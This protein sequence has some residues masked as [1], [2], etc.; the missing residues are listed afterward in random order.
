MNTNQS[1]N[2]KRSREPLGQNP[3][4][5]LR[6]L[7]RTIPGR[8]LLKPL[9]CP[10][11]SRL[12]GFFLDSPLSSFMIDPFLK[13]H[14][15]IRMSDFEKKRY[16]SYNDF[17]T[18]KIKAS[19]RPVDP[20]PKGLISPCD[21]HLSVYPIDAS[22]VFSIKD[23]CYRVSDLLGNDPCSLRFDGGY[24]LIFRLAV[25][26]YHR[27]CYPDSGTF[28]ASGSIPGEYHTVQPI[29]LEHTNI[30]KR[31][32]REYTI[33]HTDHFG[34]LAQVEVGALLVG[35]IVNH[36]AKGSFQKGSEK[37]YFEFG[38]STIVL[39]VQKDQVIIDE[40]LL[41]NTRRGKET[42][43]RFGERIGTACKL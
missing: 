18:R 25:T 9:V 26:D 21:S 13:K 32:T 22:S 35:R 8:L 15:S 37:G 39:L 33:L 14:P 36:P 24:C 40:E 29:A 5:S 27:Y 41:E 30:Y 20:D 10:L 28:G 7:Y 11:V 23:S 16:H 4:A 6:F 34:M 2:K 38:G 31:N 19:K 1:C 17:F 42:L 43:V 3:S 12:A